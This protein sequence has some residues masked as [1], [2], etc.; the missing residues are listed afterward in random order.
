L[1]VLF[2]RNGTVVS[3]L[4][5]LCIAIVFAF[6]K[7]MGPVVT[8]PAAL[9]GPGAFYA[10]VPEVVMSGVAI[11]TLGFSMVAMMMGLL[12]FW[13][14]TGAGSVAS[15]KAL[16]KALRDVLTL[17]NLGGGN[18][19][20]CNDRD[21]SFSLARRY[22]HHALFYGLLLCFA[23]TCTA[24]IYEHILGRVSPYPFFSLPVVLGSIGGI[25]LIAGTAGMIWIKLSGDRTPFA[26]AMLGPDYALLV[27]LLLAAATGLL[28]LTLR[29]TSAM[30]PLLALHLGVILSFFIALPYSKFVHGIYRTAALLRNAVESPEEARP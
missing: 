30:P 16:K 28:L 24:G 14:D 22:F 9:R 7:R 3:A 29:S 20:G 18:S 10:I 21:D 2:R 4:L 17:R 23:S 5:A 8:N 25:G 11:I 19:E 1:A 15:A 6:V 12:N 26:K 27:L 13:R